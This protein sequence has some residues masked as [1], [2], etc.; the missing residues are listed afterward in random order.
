MWLLFVSPD[1]SQNVTWDGIA[2]ILMHLSLSISIYLYSNLAIN[3]SSCVV[4]GAVVYLSFAVSW[5]QTVRYTFVFATRQDR[6][7]KSPRFTDTTSLKKLKCRWPQVTLSF[8]SRSYNMIRHEPGGDVFSLKLLSQIHMKEAKKEM[9]KSFL[10]S[11]KRRLTI[12]QCKLSFVIFFLSSFLSNP[13][14]YS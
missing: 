9:R 1:W 11:C 3:A 5:C 10:Q 4:L 12:I 7:T 13:C 2:C 6:N 8:S 14:L